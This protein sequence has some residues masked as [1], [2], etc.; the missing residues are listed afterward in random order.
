[1]LFQLTSVY[2]R[3]GQVMLRLGQFSSG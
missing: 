2:A 3:L 1:M